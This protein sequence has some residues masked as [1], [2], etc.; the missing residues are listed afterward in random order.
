MGRDIHPYRNASYAWSSACVSTSSGL[1][2]SHGKRGSVLIKLIQLL[3]INKDGYCP[4]FVSLN[5]SRLCISSL[6]LIRL[7]GD[8]SD[9]LHLHPAVI[10]V[11]AILGPTS[12]LRAQVLESRTPYLIY[13][14]CSKFKTCCANI[15]AV[16]FFLYIV[17]C[18]SKDYYQNLWQT[19]V[20]KLVKNSPSHML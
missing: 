13:S 3:K 16:T 19:K 2:L 17:L 11:S 15:S 12:P 1:F 7:L 18:I 20:H 9:G 10:I 4:S 6:P 5:D 14:F 8:L